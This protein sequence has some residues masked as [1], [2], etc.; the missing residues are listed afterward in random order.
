[1]QCIL[2]SAYHSWFPDVET[3]QQASPSPHCNAIPAA[4]PVHHTSDVTF[5]FGF[6]TLTDN[7][8]A[9][10]MISI[11]LRDETLWAILVGSCQ[12][13]THQK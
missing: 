1:M 13:E 3:W 9:L 10:A 7:C 5:A 11:L 2:R 4:A 6:V 8:F 12:R